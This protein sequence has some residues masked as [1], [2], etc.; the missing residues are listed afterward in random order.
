MPGPPG[1]LPDVNVLARLIN[2]LVGNASQS[3]GLPE[4]W[5]DMSSSSSSPLK[6][7]SFSDLKKEMVQMDGSKW[8]DLAFVENKA[9]HFEPVKKA[10]VR[11][12]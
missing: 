7:L 10:T 3:P 5:N 11:N 12:S 9:L 1:L 6:G 2:E 8:A 4:I